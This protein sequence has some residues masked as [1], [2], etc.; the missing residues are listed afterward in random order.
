[1]G[2]FYYSSDSKGLLIRDISVVNPTWDI[3]RSRTV[4][5]TAYDNQPASWDSL[6]QPAAELEYSWVVKS[7]RSVTETFCT[8]RLA[9]R[10]QTTS[11][12]HLV[13]V[14]FIEEKL[15]IIL[16]WHIILPLPQG[17]RIKSESDLRREDKNHLLLP[18]PTPPGAHRVSCEQ[19]LLHQVTPALLPIA[20]R[21]KF[22]IHIFQL[23]QSTGI[24]WS[25]S[26]KWSSSFLSISA[27]R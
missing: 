1:M 21:R 11:P 8:P 2:D 18:I 22:K 9:V 23:P 15:E 7:Q 10:F 3:F 5:Q 17:R 26:C 6:I 20:Q 14:S 4:R 19:S 24:F 27:R 12:K 16:Y 25:L 13:V